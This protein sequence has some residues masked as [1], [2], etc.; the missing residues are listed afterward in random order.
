MTDAR[1]L[2]D[3]LIPGEGL[4]WEAARVAAGNVLMVLLAWTFLPLAWTPVPVTGQTLGVMLVAALLGSRRSALVMALYL[5]EGFAGLPVFQPLGL[6]GVARLAGPT[7]GFLLAFPVAAF[8]IGWLVERM[9]TA[10]AG[11]R[12]T[13]RLVGALV[14][15]E[16]VIFTGG[17]TWI[18]WGLGQGWPAALALGAAPFIAFEAIKIAIAVAAVRGVELA[19]AP[20]SS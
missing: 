9:V 20:R 4:L 13:A 16:L 12:R 14:A 19:R 1:V 7:A 18:A 15:G 3:R 11:W 6:P 8:V 17:C 2:A 10:A 5:A